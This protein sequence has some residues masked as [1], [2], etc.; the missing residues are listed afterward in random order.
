MPGVKV[1]EEASV[2]ETVAVQQ[3]MKDISNQRSLAGAPGAL[4]KDL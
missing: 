1:I 4:G 3:T 2:P